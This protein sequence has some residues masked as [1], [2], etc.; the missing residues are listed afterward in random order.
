VARVFAD[1]FDAPDLDA[2]VWTPHY[3]PQLSSRAQSA[4]M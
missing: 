4:A 3:L 2:D 1:E